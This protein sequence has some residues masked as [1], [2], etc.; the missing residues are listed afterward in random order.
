MEF[1]CLERTA[2]TWDR[3]SGYFDSQE[4]GLTESLY[5]LHV[6]IKMYPDNKLP[7]LANNSSFSTP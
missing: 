7:V 1:E 5:C 2:E 4:T 3:F 6:Q